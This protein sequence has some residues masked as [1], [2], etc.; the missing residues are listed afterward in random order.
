MKTSP[1]HSLFGV[2]QTKQALRLCKEGF[3]PALRLLF[4]PQ[5]ILQYP[6]LLSEGIGPVRRMLIQAHNTREIKKLIG[7][8]YPVTF[9]NSWARS[10]STLLRYLLSDIFLQQQ[11]H[12]TS[13][14]LAVLPDEIIADTYCNLIATRNKEVPT[15]GLLVKTH[16][17]FDGLRRVYC[18]EDSAVESSFRN[19]RHLYLCRSAEDALVSLYHL[20]MKRSYFLPGRWYVKSSS[21]GDIDT[22]CREALPQWT[23]HVSSYLQAAES[24]V[25]IFFVSYEHLSSEPAEILGQ[26][27]RWLG[28][29]FTPTM[30]KR[31][32][33][34]MDFQ[35]VKAVDPR[36]LGNQPPVLRYGRKG[37]GLIELQPS[38]IDYIRA[39][40]ESL[41]AKV[42]ALAE[43]PSA[44]TEETASPVPLVA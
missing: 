14:K 4:H 10:G 41:T 27:L 18:G 29:P 11:G 20:H 16:D 37:G 17:L 5:T 1:N 9:I 23:N 36:S 2:K 12:E 44:L 26:V 43:R 13:T 6:R 25:P 28:V 15:P 7:E 31:A 39:R 24:G 33:S 38:T 22:F 21:R 8:G 30:V 40:T 32:A 34:N 42:H 3:G 35:K 19:C